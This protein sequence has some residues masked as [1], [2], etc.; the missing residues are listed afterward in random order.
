MILANVSGVRGRRLERGRAP[1]VVLFTAL[2]A[3]IAGGCGVGEAAQPPG[4]DHGGAA[5]AE[6]SAQPAGSPPS[7]QTAPGGADGCLVTDEAG[8][9]VWEGSPSPQAQ[10]VSDR[11]VA[12]V[13]AAPEEFTGTAFC[14]RY[15]GIVVF[16][17]GET[18]SVAA[19]V[20]EARA[21]HPDV[22]VTVK[23]VGA[24]WAD[25]EAATQT[26]MGLEEHRGVI[27]AAGPDVRNGG[28]LVDV[29]VEDFSQDPGGLVDPDALS[30]RLGVPVRLRAVGAGS[31]LDWRAI[32]H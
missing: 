30:D 25:L 8:E 12:A 5:R 1:G 10:E 13:D 6:T 22:E 18:D 26:V 14:S 7:T 21:E 11:L 29:R 16:V 20:A 3:L 19:L 17:K 23:P 32:A 28:V 15:E 24:S 31:R 4:G 27:G 2:A 9:L